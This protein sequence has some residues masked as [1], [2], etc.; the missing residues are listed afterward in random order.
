VHPETSMSEKDGQGLCPRCVHVRVV[1][2]DRGSRFLLCRLSRS[3]AR[4]PKFPPQP[5]R[6][7]PGF[8]RSAGKA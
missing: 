2:N 1:V 7:C 8:E 3:D 6:A 4:Y 5:V